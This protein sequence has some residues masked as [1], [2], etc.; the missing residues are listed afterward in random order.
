MAYEIKITPCLKAGC[1]AVRTAVFVQEQGFQQE[2]DAIDDRAWHVLICDGEIP[3]ATGRLYTTDGDHFVI[4]RVAVMP[5]YRGAHL[6]ERVVSA[7]EEQAAKCG[8]SMISLSAQCRAMGFYEKLG[9]A[10]KGDSYM[11]EFCPHI[12]MVKQLS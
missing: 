3:V 9:Y 8:G 6:G 7:L 11:D 1:A 2:F 12:T 10:P 5:D 4:G